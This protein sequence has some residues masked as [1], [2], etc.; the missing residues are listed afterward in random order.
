MV[1]N[2][3]LFSILSY[4]S[5]TR[6]LQIIS[7]ILILRLLAPEQ[8]G[9][10]VLVLAIISIFEV[11]VG[12][13]LLISVIGAKKIDME[14]LNRSLSLGILVALTISF[15]LSPLAWILQN[16]LVFLMA[17]S[18]ILRPYN[19]VM[20][21]LLTR[22][23]LFHNLGFR[24]FAAS[25][26]SNFVVL[27]LF[28]L[29]IDPALFL[30]IRYLLS[31]IILFLLH[32]PGKKLALR[33]PINNLAYLQFLK[34]GL[35]K[36]YSNLLEIYTSKIDDLIIGQTISRANL[37]VYEVGFQFPQT[38]RTLTI[39]SIFG[40]I[41]GVYRKMDTQDTRY[42]YTQIGMVSSIFATGF[43]WIMLIFGQ[44]LIENLFGIAYRDS[45]NI[46]VA[47]S[48]SLSI[49]FMAMSNM[50]LLVSKQDSTGSIEISLF[51]AIIATLLYGFGSQGGIQQIANLAIAVSLFYYLHSS[52]VC[53]RYNLIKSKDLLDVFI[54]YSIFTLPALLFAI[55]SDLFNMHTVIPAYILG[56]VYVGRSLISK[57]S[58]LTFSKVRRLT[59]PSENRE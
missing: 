30:Y 34:P 55:Q 1:K 47:I 10:Y 51:S 14:V 58:I 38:F 25:C 23:F 44:P 46:T 12:D 2:H 7:Y 48:L 21:G 54:A 42:F 43:L 20:E 40:Y 50:P 28:L 32:L 36:L 57:K 53:T 19:C 17:F 26:I 11:L 24:E 45:F 16:N 13:Y 52:Y 9:E 59:N 41:V 33:N 39:G 35:R 4:R 15:I 8:L 3:P 29:S 6:F 31:R 37:A 56:G 27:G 18:L 22:N 5:A 49:R